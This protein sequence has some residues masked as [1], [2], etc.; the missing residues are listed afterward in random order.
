MISRAAAAIQKKDLQD[1]RLHHCNSPRLKIAS[2][3]SKSSDDDDNDCQDEGRT[4]T[5][6]DANAPDSLAR[7]VGGLGAFHWLSLSLS[8]FWHDEK[9]SSTRR[10][11]TTDRPTETMTVKDRV[12]AVAR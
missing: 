1:G 6:A 7:S 8:R 10:T 12:S 4:R 9:S 5:D 2:H 11:T 3:Q